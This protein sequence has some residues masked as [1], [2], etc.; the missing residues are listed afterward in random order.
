V[1]L[2][3]FCLCSSNA[4]QL[5]QGDVGVLNIG[6]SFIN[7]YDYFGSIDVVLG[8]LFG[9]LF[10]PFAIFV[11]WWIITPPSTV[12]TESMVEMNVS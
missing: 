1:L 7:G 2:N 5:Q 6:E 8:I 4:L 3:Y 10:L 9:L 11:A 12:L